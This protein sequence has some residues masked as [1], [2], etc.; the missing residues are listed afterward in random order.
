MARLGR[1]TRSIAVKY[2]RLAALAKQEKRSADREYLVVG[3]DA[4]AVD[5]IR[6]R[7]GAFG[8]LPEEIPPGAE[9][10]VR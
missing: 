6:D 9:A 1:Q 5:R 3:W 7:S 10:E 4:E 2:S 8:V